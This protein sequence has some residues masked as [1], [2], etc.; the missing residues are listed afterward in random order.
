MRDC[1]IRKQI[2]GNNTHIAW[3]A[4]HISA[5]SLTLFLMWFIFSI[6]T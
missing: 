1:L 2:I 4:Q 5:F 6:N 3:V